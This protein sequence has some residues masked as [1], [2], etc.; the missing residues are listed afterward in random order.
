MKTIE[1]PIKGDLYPPALPKKPPIDGDDM[2]DRRPNNV[3]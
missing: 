1:T 3:I 2:I